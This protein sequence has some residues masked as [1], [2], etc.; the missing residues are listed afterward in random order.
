MPSFQ[1]RSLLLA[2]VLPSALC[3]CI[4]TGT[5]TCCFV[6]DLWVCD[7]CRRS[8]LNSTIHTPLTNDTQRSAMT[9]SNNFIL[10]QDHS[11]HAERAVMSDPT[12][13]E[14]SHATLLSLNSILD[15]NKEL[16]YGSSDATDLFSPR[17]MHMLMIACM[18]VDEIYEFLLFAGTVSKLM[19]DADP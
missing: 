15:G 8:L 5:E 3:T 4:D 9:E 19:L 6:A 10:Y 2:L 7:N 14:Q 1:I 16:G 13:S 18:C 17:G 11:D 12:L